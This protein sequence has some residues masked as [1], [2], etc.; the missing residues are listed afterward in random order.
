MPPSWNIFIIDEWSGNTLNFMRE[1]TNIV[2]CLLGG[3]WES[4]ISMTYRLVL[5]SLSSSTGLKEKNILPWTLLLKRKTNIHNH[6]PNQTLKREHMTPDNP[7]WFLFYWS[8]RCFFKGLKGLLHSRSPAP[9]EV[10][11]WGIPS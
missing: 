11:L 6:P 7:S 9:P 2:S 3:T 4:L 1:P 10:A 8:T 5:F